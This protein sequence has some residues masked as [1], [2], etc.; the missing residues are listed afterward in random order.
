MKVLENQ[1]SKVLHFR[2]VYN[3]FSFLIS[4]VSQLAYAHM[5]N[6]TES[7]FSRQA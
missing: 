1:P 5:I 7:L 6:T 4:M 3:F 2:S